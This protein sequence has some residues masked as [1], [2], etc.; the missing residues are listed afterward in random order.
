MATV[1]DQ[2]CQQVERMWADTNR[3]PALE[4]TSLPSL[5][6]EASKPIDDRGDFCGHGGAA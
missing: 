6:L 2:H 1:L 5:E 3:H 4:E